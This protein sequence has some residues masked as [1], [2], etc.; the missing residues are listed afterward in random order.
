MFTGQKAITRFLPCRK[1]AAFHLTLP[2]VLKVQL[3]R[4]E[5][6]LSN[7]VIM[8]NR[9]YRNS[10]LINCSGGGKTPYWPVLG[11]GHPM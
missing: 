9:K 11:C 1:A 5:C 10:G 7:R 8:S 3:D 4:L 6:L 2:R